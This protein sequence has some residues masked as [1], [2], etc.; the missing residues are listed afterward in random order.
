[1]ESFGDR[2][3]NARLNKGLKQADVAERLG[4]AA[5]SLTNWESGKIMPSMDVLS[6]LCAVYEVSPL[7]LLSNVYS[8]S[9]IVAIA[10]KPVPERTYEEQVAINFSHS[11]LEKLMAS[12][13]QRAE[14]RRIEDTAN[15]LHS[16]N[17]LAR[18]GMMNKKQIEAFRA[19]FENNGKA[20]ND[21]LFAYHILTGDNKRA[22]LSMLSGLI[23]QPDNVQNLHEKMDKATAYTIEQ[24]ERERKELTKKGAD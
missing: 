15:F 16:T 9:D 17:L 3:K 13:L 22:F 1:M 6:R 8:Y 11:I 4:C 24:L 7:S 23:A 19:D 2:L 10:D 18:F 14:T 20:D 21:I 12:E 5:T